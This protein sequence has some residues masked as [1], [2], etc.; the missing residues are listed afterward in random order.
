MRRWVIVA[1]LLFLVP[2]STT[3][4]ADYVLVRIVCPS[5]VSVKIDWE[6]HIGSD[7][8]FTESPYSSGS[9]RAGTFKESGR[10]A[11]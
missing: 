7:P 1:T 11:R 6:K 5:V 10:R 3:Q 2:E 8:T 4:G 9:S